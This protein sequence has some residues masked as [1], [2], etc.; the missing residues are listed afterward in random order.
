MASFIALEFMNNS[1]FYLFIIIL[2]CSCGQGTTVQENGNIKKIY[3]P[4][5]QLKELTTWEDGVMHGPFE[6]YFEN[7]NPEYKGRMNRGK[8]QGTVKY[9]DSVSGKVAK[10]VNYVVFS[11]YICF[12]S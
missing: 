9:Y 4:N 5:G 11:R 12:L 6:G 8:K 2:F 7:G 10:W 3:Y 1:K